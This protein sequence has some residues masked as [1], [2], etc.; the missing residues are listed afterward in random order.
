MR[1]SA[2]AVTVD[3]V[4]L[5]VPVPLAQRFSSRAWIALD[6]ALAALIAAGTVAIP[7]GG[8]QFEPA[9]AGWDAARVAAVVLVCALLPFRRW[10]PRVVLVATTVISSLLLA[11]GLPGPIPVVVA[12][13][14]YTAVAG[15]NRRLSAAVGGTVVVVLFATALI[16]RHGPDWAQVVSAPALVVAAWLAGVNTR[17]R[18]AYMGGLVA[19]AA[20]QAAR[21]TTEERIRIAQEL[22]DVVAHSMSVIAVRSGVGR[23]VAVDQP[24]QAVEALSIIETTSQRALAEL[25]VILAVLRDGDATAVQLDPVRSLGD[26]PQLMSE[27]GHAGVSVAFHIEGEPR[28]LAPGIEV[29]A[30]RIVQEALTNVVRHAGATT[31]YLCVRYTPGNLEIEVCDDGRSKQSHGARGRT[32][33]G[34]GYGLVGMRERVAVYGGEF[35]AGPTDNGFRVVARLPTRGV[36]S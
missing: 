3:D 2:D 34:S 30:Y 13:C 10:R 11:S 20:E 17:V 5:G 32:P 35:R 28:V 15:S 29:S 19:R 25:R 21:A 31:A 12:L 9:G 4:E 14:L 24:Q 7:A 1:R 27:V 22:H 16:G 33:S 26:L 6:V 36:G 18:R 23:M 8:Y